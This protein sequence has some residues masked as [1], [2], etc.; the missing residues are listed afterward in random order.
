M[1]STLLPAFVL[2]SREFLSQFAIP[3]IV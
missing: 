3:L 1:L 2:V